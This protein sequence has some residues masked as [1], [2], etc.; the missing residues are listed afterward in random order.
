M[1]KILE[2]TLDVLYEMR[3]V[4]SMH[5]IGREQYMEAMNDLRRAIRCLENYKFGCP[6][7]KHAGV[8]RCKDSQA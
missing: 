3:E 4:L 2:D 6:E 1:K 7:G 5:K 8:C